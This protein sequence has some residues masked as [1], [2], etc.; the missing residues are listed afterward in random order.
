MRHCP[1]MKALLCVLV[2]C[3]C[4]WANEIGDRRAIINTI[5]AL[6]E[7]PQPADLFTSDADGTDIPQATYGKANPWNSECLPDVPITPP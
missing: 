1:G 4:G 3:V 7:F 6:N 2:T 5:A